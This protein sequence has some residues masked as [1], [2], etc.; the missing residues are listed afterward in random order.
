MRKLNR[1]VASSI[2]LAAALMPISSN[3]GTVTRTL[4]RYAV[5]GA[6]IGAMLGAGAAT[7]SYINTNQSFDFVTGAGLGILA[8]AGLGYIFGIFDLASSK[9]KQMQKPAAGE[10]IDAEADDG[11]AFVSPAA[12]SFVAWSPV[13]PSVAFQF[14]F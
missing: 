3:S 9:E 1:I 7:L 5:G 14:R 11:G 8:G 2:L 13:G 6:G 12:Q 10:G 4:G